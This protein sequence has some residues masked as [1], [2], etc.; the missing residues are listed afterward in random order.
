MIVA[1]KSPVSKFD[2]LDE[3]FWLN[4]DLVESVSIVNAIGLKINYHS[5]QRDT[6]QFG[7]V[8]QYSSVSRLVKFSFE[9]YGYKK[10][11]YLNY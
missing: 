6:Q 7:Y 11:N 5:M 8:P 4:Y 10:Y 3:F 9:V 2:L 1:D